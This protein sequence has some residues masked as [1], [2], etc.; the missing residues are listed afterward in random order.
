MAA[1]GFRNRASMAAAVLGTD[2]E[3]IKEKLAK[4]HS[5]EKVNA[6]DPDLYRLFHRLAGGRWTVKYFGDVYERDKHLGEAIADTETGARCEQLIFSILPATKPL[7]SD[8]RG[9]SMP[10]SCARLRERK[11]GPN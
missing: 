7:R 4:G 2:L 1:C 9:F 11:H 8:P 5:S 3:H 6:Q 10:V